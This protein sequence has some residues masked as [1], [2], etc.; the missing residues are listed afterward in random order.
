MPMRMWPVG[1]LPENV[2]TSTEDDIHYKITDISVI[3][4]TGKIIITY[5]D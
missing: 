4:A 3:Q 1:I 2:I 5:E